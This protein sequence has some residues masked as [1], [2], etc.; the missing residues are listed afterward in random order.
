MPLK[1]NKTKFAILGLLTMGPLSGY[2]I[3]KVTDTSI[4][5]FWNENFG[6]IYPI[7]KRLEKERL[8]AK[9]AENPERGP[10]RNVYTIPP[11]GKKQLDAWLSE[12]VSTQPVRCE[13][14]L[15]LFFGSNAKKQDLT[16]LILAE[17]KQ[18]EEMLARLE[19]VG[20][21]IAKKK[22][23]D[24][25]F[26]LCTLSYGLRKASMTISWCDEVLGSLNR[27]GAEE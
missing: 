2:D 5:F 14:L 1:V 21:S 3:K 10:R 24:L 25:P 7:L 8:V 20:E 26:W 22:S 12:P 15:K 18:Q 16:K 4:G 11:L 19:A 27:R 13:L 23:K 17:K 6:H 9:K